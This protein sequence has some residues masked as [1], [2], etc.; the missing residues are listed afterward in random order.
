MTLAIALWGAIVATLNVLWTIW[1]DAQDSGRVQIGVLVGTSRSATGE[2][3]ALAEIEITNVGRRELRPVLVTVIFDGGRFR[4]LYYKAP[5]LPAQILV[6]AER[7]VVA[8]IHG[9]EVLKL[10]NVIV[11]DTA[12][13]K[14]R[15]GR[16]AAR[17][18]R[19]V[20]AE[21]LAGKIPDGALTVEGQ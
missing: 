10:K 2:V 17:R 16:I 5:H 20:A 14:H 1:R 13:R 6:P 19:Q 3:S 9:D 7:S 4:P 18:A 21:R 11:L 8:A 12:N 15:L